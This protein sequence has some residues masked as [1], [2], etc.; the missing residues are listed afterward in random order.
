MLDF[1]VITEKI[2]KPLIFF[3]ILIA[4]LMI[5]SNYLT[6]ISK[7]NDSLIPSRNKNIIML[8]KERENTIDVM[9]IGDSETY[10]SFSPL[11]MWKNY[12]ITAF[13]GG[14]S[15][16]T[17]QEAYSMLETAFENQSPKVVMLETNIM[18]RAQKGVQ[19]MKHNL[20]E[21]GNYWFPVFRYHDVWKPMLL[22]NKYADEVYKGFI[23]RSAIQPYKGGEYMIETEEKQQITDMVSD[24]MEKIVAMCE[25]HDAKLFLI[26][27]P[28]PL[29]YNYKKHNTISE[30]AQKNNLDYLD[31]NLR[32]DE[33]GI[34]WN[35]D[36]F[37]KGDHLNLLGAN[38]VS[39]YTGKYL[40]DLYNLEDNRNL[41]DSTWGRELKKYDK[42]V[43]KK[44]Q[45]M[46]L[47]NK[48]KI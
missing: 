7:N 44:I 13:V 24:Y 25:K 10:N 35:M 31:L 36:T 34:D 43:S 28:S 9:I 33:L 2:K 42:I 37:D 19:G 32:I 17:I 45:L 6:E 20:V 41:N 22:G 4:I 23:L 47:N 8:Q 1:K 39:D 38:K 11:K 3:T 40:K 30:F 26:S 14:Q 16:Q 46:K 18:F 15:G 29:N 5:A 48:E 21:I 12:G 27:A